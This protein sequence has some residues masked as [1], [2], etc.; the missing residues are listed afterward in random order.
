VICFFVSSSIVILP[1][2]VCLS[3]TLYH[4]YDQIANFIFAQ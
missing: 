3:D 4:F 2:V 1:F